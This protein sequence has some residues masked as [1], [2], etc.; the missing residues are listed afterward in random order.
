MDSF[1]EGVTKA[2]RKVYNALSLNE[3][4]AEGKLTPEEFVQAGDA[5]VHKFPAWKWGSGKHQVEYLPPNKQYLITEN[6]PSLQRVD[7]L[8]SKTESITVEGDDDDWVGIVGA[9]AVEIEEYHPDGDD[10]D[11]DDDDDEIPDLDDFDPDLV[12]EDIATLQDED[13]ILKTRTYD[14]SI[15]YDKYYRTPRIWLFGYDENRKPLQTQE[16]FADI[17][18]AHRK[19]TV[20][21]DAHPHL[22]SQQVYIHPCKHAEYM[23]KIIG[24]FAESGKE[25]RITN[26]YLSLLL[27]LIS[28]VIPTIEYD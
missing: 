27:K 9:K 18:A 26:L 16:I 11:D 13:T 8:Y 14:I 10:D 22:E 23:K 28:S 25:V 5:L 19:K 7:A 3:E 24:K 12:D 20:A 15:T 21:F 2:K 17:S 1:L 4:F 6:V